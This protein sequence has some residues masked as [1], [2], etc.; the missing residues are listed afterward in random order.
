MEHMNM[1]SIA[2]DFSVTPGPR[3]I[4]EGD[5]SGEAFRETLLKPRFEKSLEKKEKLVVDLD[6]TVGYGTS[7]LEESFGGLARTYGS[8]SVMNTIDIISNEEPYL[9]DDV[10]DYILKAND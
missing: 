2:R 7:F 10:S 4:V 9:K 1:I 5:F 8:D 6:G 3:L